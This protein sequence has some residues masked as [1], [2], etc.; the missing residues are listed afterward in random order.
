MC[1][2]PSE[3]RMRSTEFGLGT[4]SSWAASLSWGGDGG[5]GNCSSAP[6]LSY[7]VFCNK[8]K[9]NFISS[10][11]NIINKI[12]DSWI[13]SYKY[14]H[15]LKRSANLLRIATLMHQ[16]FRHQFWT[17]IQNLSSWLR[18]YPLV[19]GTC[20]GT[21]VTPAASANTCA[22]V[23]IT[24]NCIS[25]TIIER[26][27]FRAGMTFLS[28]TFSYFDRH[29]EHIITKSTPWMTY[30][31]HPVYHRAKTARA[32]YFENIYFS[33][34]AVHQSPLDLPLRKFQVKWKC[35]IIMRKRREKVNDEINV[36]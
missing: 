2:T 8:E 1:W 22:A 20:F 13:Y 28:S 16:S 25:A 9:S 24:R 14:K 18:S 27:Q 11:H 15:I 17:L 32:W 36:H 26:I 10:C 19:R 7:L 12:W 35:Y 3:W 31:R 6:A 30:D 4:P 29:G 33:V 21:Y 23:G 5:G 34:Y